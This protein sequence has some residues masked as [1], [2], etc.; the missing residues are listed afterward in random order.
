MSEEHTTPTSGDQ[1]AYEARLRR[2]LEILK[3]ELE[4]GNIKIVE[5]L[6]V[7][8]SLENVRYAPDGSI[9]LASVDSFVR[10]MALGVEAFH[11]RRELKEA[12]PLA[13]IQNTYFT[14]LE[15]NFGAYYK[16]M[17]ER[18]LTP[19]DAGK[20]LSQND[21]SITQLNE[22]LDDFLETVNEFWSQTAE[23]AHAHIEDMH[24]SLK[25]VFGGD[26]FPSP[27][28]NIASKCGLYT[29]TIIL[30]CP[31]LRSAHIFERTTPQR[32]AY[33]LI[34]HALNILKYKELACCEVS[35]PIVVVL[36]DMSAIEEQEKDYFFRLGQEDAL[37]HAEKIFGRSFDT[38]ESLLE[39]ATELE[40]IEDVTRAVVDPKRV[41]FDTE[42]TGS[43]EDQLK[44]AAEHE[45]SQL[46]GIKNPGVIL[47]SQALGR[48]STSNELL[49]KA[50]RL[51]GTPLIDAPTSWQFFSWKLEYDAGRAQDQDSATDLHMLRGLQDLAENEM[52]WLGDVPPAAL[53]QVRKDGALAE[54][55]S[56][57]QQGVAELAELNPAN[58][59]RTGD[60]VFDNVQNAFDEHKKSIR[61]L[62]AKGWKFAGSDV[63]SW[64]VVG[65]LAVTAAATGMPVWGLA[66]IAADQMLDAPKLKDIP[67]SIRKLA[68]ESTE[69][70]Q[71]P[72]GLL[73]KYSGERA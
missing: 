50:R 42:W 32:R 33:Y 45:T 31:F 73:F 28:E 60:Q 10:S 65:S 2:R 62:R 13:E 38:F 37:I 25:G 17:E 57:L 26:L 41:L 8:N 6:Q 67:E 46:L 40:T 48:M 12:I 18:S 4:A 59:H 19:H 71:S 53:I 55:R 70:K 27:Y 58:F 64:F 9:D 63:G 49:I 14:F 34:K 30:P 39:Y 29:D 21:E 3:A 51:R 66:A 68:D 72:V 22:N 54:I 36:P 61:D 56:I 15:R 16:T 11:D 23:A 1:A 7:G 24:D 5:G 43:L 20:A 69:L 52:E 44:R 47:A 35:P